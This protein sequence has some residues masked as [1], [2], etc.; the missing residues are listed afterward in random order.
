[1]AELLSDSGSRHWLFTGSAIRM[2]E[3]MRLNKEFHQKH[4]FQEQE[5]RRRTF[6]ACFL[7]DRMLAYL[8]GKHRTINPDTV[9]IATPVT[10]ASLAF[11][12]ETKGVM[13]SDIAL[14]RRPSELGLSP[15]FLRTV[16]LWSDLADFSIY[17]RR[18]F[19]SFPPTDPHSIFSIRHEALRGWIDALPPSLAW[20]IPNFNNHRMLGQSE[21]FVSMQFLL[22]SASCVAHQSYLPQLTMYT[23]VV[24][25]TDAAGWSYLHRDETLIETCVTSALKMGEMLN[26]LM[27]LEQVAEKSNIRTVWVASAI[28]TA[29]NTYLWLQY[30]PD[31][32]FSSENYRQK[33]SQYLDIIQ[34]L[35]ESWLPEWEVARQWSRA[36]KAM[37]ALYKASYLGEIDESILGHD[38]TTTEHPD[39]DFRPQPG[40]GYPSLLSLPNLQASVKFAT[41]DTS[42][43][44]INIHSIWL[45]LCGGWP[46]GFVGQEWLV[47]SDIEFNTT[48]DIL[49]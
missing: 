1:M 30:T 38:G 46:R 37:Q 49:S 21:A 12:E 34:Q 15:F 27:D 24:D 19:D 40:D 48:M 4:S 2:A 8:L 45:Q 36:L 29:V 5:I 20:S 14:Y 44:S 7:F 6:W 17:S 41:S 28:L 11:G 39:L 3:I 33:G 32:V 23:K 35:V 43:R 25:L 31:E 22:H 9:S 16:S 10:D 13:L 26:Y 47:G 42:A 18:H